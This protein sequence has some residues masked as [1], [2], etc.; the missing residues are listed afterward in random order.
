M[1]RDHRTSDV[2][3][4]WLEQPR[5]KRRQ[6]VSVYVQMSSDDDLK[7]GQCE[8]SERVAAAHI[9]R[10]LT[11]TWDECFCRMPCS[12]S[13]ADG[14]LQAKFGQRELATQLSTFGWSSTK[15]STTWHCRVACGVSHLVRVQP[16]SRQRDT[17]EWPAEYHVWIGVQPK[18]HTT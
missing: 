9:W 6:L 3:C 8:P 10:R 15:V 16:G 11:P 18:S 4:A 1:P 2:T 13:H 12:N 14:V 5:S 7:S 17:A